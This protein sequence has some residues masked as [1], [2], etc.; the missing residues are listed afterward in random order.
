MMAAAADAEADLF[1]GHTFSTFDEFEAHFKT[2]CQRTR[3][4]YCVSYSKT[5]E[6]YNRLRTKK[7]DPRLKYSCIQYTC[8][9]G[10]TERHRGTGIRPVQRFVDDCL[11]KKYGVGEP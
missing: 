5:V 1:V 9:S 10:G 4:I 6:H 11:K 8:K 7:L 3:Q 2:Y